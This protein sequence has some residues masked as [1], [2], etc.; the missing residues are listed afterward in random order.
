MK[1]IT[2]SMAS[3]NPGGRDVTTINRHRFKESQTTV[4]GIV[5]SIFNIVLS[6]KI[7]NESNVCLDD[8]VSS[9][10]RSI[11]LMESHL[12]LLNDVDVA[13]NA[14]RP[15]NRRAN[16]NR[17]LSLT[18]IVCVSIMFSKYGSLVSRLRRTSTI[19]NF[20]RASFR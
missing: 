6:N 3:V 11:A 13:N 15:C 2:R 18:S 19:P 9:L 16:G 1:C 8:I 17:A 5:S 7:N 10:V 20:F 14:L 12:T 4:L